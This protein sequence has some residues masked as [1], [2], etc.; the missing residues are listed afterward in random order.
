MEAETFLLLNFTKLS[1]QELSVPHFSNTMLS[2]V[3]IS[4]LSRLY[5]EQDKLLVSFPIVQ[6]FSVKCR[7]E[8]SSAQSYGS[9]ERT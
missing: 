1:T 8:N 3:F 2:A 5:L 9:F 6:D 4:Q 7:F